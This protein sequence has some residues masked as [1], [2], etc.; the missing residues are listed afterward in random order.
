MKLKKITL[1]NTFAQHS[2]FYSFTVCILSIKIKKSTITHIHIHVFIENR[3]I[4]LKCLSV[5]Y[6]YL[7]MPTITAISE[8]DTIYSYQR[9]WAPVHQQ[10]RSIQY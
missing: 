10:G 4:K 9:S 3:I 6:L 8:S 1:K 2:L 5:I 7:S